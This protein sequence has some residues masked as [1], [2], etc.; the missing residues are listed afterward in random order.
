LFV[1]CLLLFAKPQQAS[2][3]G[4][5]QREKPR[6]IAIVK[7]QSSRHKPAQAL[8]A[9]HRSP[10]R[11]MGEGATM[12]RLSITPISRAQ[13]QKCDLA[14]T[15]ILAGNMDFVARPMWRGRARHIQLSPTLPFSLPHSLFILPLTTY[16]LLSNTRTSTKK[17]MAATRHRPQ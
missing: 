7:A 3:I 8:T 5:G 15:Q 9:A 12:V 4:G 16:H 14:Q 1:H 13:T 17:T 2:K 11:K 6:A 10:W